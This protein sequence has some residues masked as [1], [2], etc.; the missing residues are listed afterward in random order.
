MLL[1]VYIILTILLN[2][3]L[4]LTMQYGLLYTLPMIIDRSVSCTLL[5]IYYICYSK[6]IFMEKE[7]YLESNLC[8]FF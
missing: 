8:I 4:Q 1:W 5:I 2:S 6:N 3:L 7:K